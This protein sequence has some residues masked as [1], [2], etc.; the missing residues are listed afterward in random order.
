MKREIKKIIEESGVLK[1]LKT[2]EDVSNLL[3]ELHSD[4]LEAM[5][6]GELESHLGYARNE[7]S[8]SRNARNGTT[9]KRLKTEFGESTIEVPRDR[10]G[11]F[12]PVIVAKHQS[13]AP[14]WKT[15]SYRFTPRE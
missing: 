4:L 5:L 14:R 3:K 11:T 2:Q 8:E 12:E 1:G 6:H 7:K 10:Q 15:S 9:P 13:T